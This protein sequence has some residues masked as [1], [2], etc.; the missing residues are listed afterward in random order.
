MSQPPKPPAPPGAEQPGDFKVLIGKDGKPLA[1]D[2]E[3]IAALQAQAQM[4]KARVASLKAE[5]DATKAELM[6]PGAAPAIAGNQI[7][8][9]QLESRRTDAEEALEKI[10]NQLAGIGVT[11]ATVTEIGTPMPFEPLIP[12]DPNQDALQEKVAIISVAAIVF[13]GAPI[14]IAIARF[15]W[16]RTTSRPSQA[17]APSGDDTRR[18][19]RVE[20]AV[21]AIAVEVERMSEGQ[22]YVTRL[23]AE[24]AGA[25]AAEPVV[26]R[27]GVKA[28]QR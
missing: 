9:T 6:A 27:D 15:I 3:A 20:Q 16:K 17:P 23:L 1:G 7:R 5:I 2:G 25:P 24:R 10:E 22:R 28:A 26:A 12:F 19:E 14:A 21:D 8:L 18:L 4:L 13:I 11:P